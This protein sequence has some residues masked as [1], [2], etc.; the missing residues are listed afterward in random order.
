MNAKH[1]LLSALTAFAALSLSASENNVK[2]VAHMGY[3][4]AP[5]SAQNSIDAM[6]QAAKVGFDGTEFDVCMTS[7]SVVVVNHDGRINGHNIEYTPSEIVCAKK[8]SNGEN[9]PTLDA[10]FLEATKY[11]KLRLVCEMKVSDSR[12]HQLEMARQICELAKKHG[13][14]DRIDY[15]TFSRDGMTSLKKYAPQGTPIYYLTGD[16]VPEQLKY[17]GAAGADYGIWI[18]QKHPEWVKQLHDLGMKVNVWTVDN[19]DG[20]KW[21]IDNGVDFITTNYPERFMEIQKT[22]K[23]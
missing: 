22:Y 1:I 4:R 16:Y 13:L 8:L 19:E 12:G 2:V 15:I 14:E 23:P 18:F 7:D 11:P 3:W 10:F 21:C 6:V 5:G 17:M 9:V 20:M